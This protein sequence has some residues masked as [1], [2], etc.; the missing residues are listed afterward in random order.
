MKHE[1]QRTGDA[2]V[3]YQFASTQLTQLDIGVSPVNKLVTLAVLVRYGLIC[4]KT[5][6]RRL[7]TFGGILHA[8]SVT[9][10][11]C[12]DELEP[13]LRKTSEQNSPGPVCADEAAAGDCEAQ[14]L[15]APCQLRCS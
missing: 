15:V 9:G 6:H 3:T 8:T 4:A 13:V 5:T 12:F 2:Q 14:E 10:K 7:D 1:A 11:F